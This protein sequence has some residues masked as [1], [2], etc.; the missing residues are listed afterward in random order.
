MALVRGNRGRI[1]ALWPRV[2]TEAK[3]LSLTFHYTN[4]CATNNT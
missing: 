1:G 4:N 2:A 3:G